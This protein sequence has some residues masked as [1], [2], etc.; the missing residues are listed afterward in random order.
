[1]LISPRRPQPRLLVWC[2]FVAPIVGLGA[3]ACGGEGGGSTAES[4]STGD[5]MSTGGSATDAPTGG[6]GETG[7]SAT[8]ASTGDTP[9][10]DGTTGG[11]PLT[12]V[13]KIL[14]GLDVAMYE[15]PERVWPDV[16]ANYR[17]RQVVLASQAENKA[18]V[19][20]YQDGKG[21]PP[22]VTQGPLDALPPEWTSDFNVG[23]LG[24]APALGISLDWTQEINDGHLMAGGVLWPDFG[25]VLS[26][27][28]GFHF[29]SDQDDWSTGSGSRS[30]PY[31]APWEPR[32]LRGQ[33]RRTLLT[34]A[35]GDDAG[36]GAAAFW[37]G[38]LQAEYGEEMQTIRSYDCTEGSAEYVALMMSALAE[39]GCDA[40]DEELVAL[41]TSHLKDGIF[42]VE[43]SFDSGREPYDL[44]VLAG[45]LLRGQGVKGWELKVETGDPPADQVLAGVQA[46]DQP[47]DPVVE[48]EAK[49][50]V[51]AG[52]EVVGAEIDPLVANLKDPKYTRIPVSQG[53]IQGSFGLGGFYY[54]ADDPLESEVWLNLS[55]TLAPPSNVGIEVMGLTSFADVATACNLSGPGTIVLVVPTADVSVVGGE[56]TVAS[57]KL[58]VD[59]LAVVET[60]DD[61]NLPWLCPVDGGGGAPAPGPEFVVERLR[62]GE[63]AKDQS[64]TTTHRAWPRAPL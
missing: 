24:S 41:A 51:D 44:G 49:A 53:W 58:A 33:L 15:C 29:L 3:F 43:G 28:E 46:V 11:E 42:I 39:L 21:E 62:G 37:H 47:D 59:G 60:M 18:W 2:V 54:L 20:N 9:T 40:S 64:T 19:W 10:G 38:R 31:P 55:T 30:A 52:N 27:H 1:M 61:D 5:G 63:A 22:V 48:M 34:A 57:A 56:A 13:E 14:A 25:S 7:E 50:E 32:Y 12:R 26:Y 35:L 16:E 8:D 17:S 23:T 6:T 45:L 36:L 4:A